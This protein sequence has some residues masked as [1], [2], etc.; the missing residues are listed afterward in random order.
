MK[1]RYALFLASQ[2]IEHQTTCDD[3]PQQN[4]RVERKHKHILEVARA[5]R[6][7]TSLPLRFWA[8]CITTTTNL[9]NR[10]LSYVLKNKTPYEMLLN[11]VPD[12]THL[13]VFEC[14]FYYG[15]KSLKSG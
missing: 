6:F 1:G 8:D 4:G 12:Y 5:L 14:T 13:K 9:I 10:V 2:G 15:Y 7:Q 11:K 3:K